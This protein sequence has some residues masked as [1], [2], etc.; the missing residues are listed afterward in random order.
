MQEALCQVIQHNPRNPVY[1]ET[2]HPSQ[3]NIWPRWTGTPWSW[4]ER[5]SPGSRSGRLSGIDVEPFAATGELPDVPHADRP[6]KV[7][8]TTM[9]A[10]I[11]LARRRP[12]RVVSLIV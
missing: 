2:G 12:G 7:Q 8:R 11:A 5:P 3:A 6:D 9:R 10:V 1:R 4:P